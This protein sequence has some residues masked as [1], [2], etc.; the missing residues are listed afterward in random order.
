[1]I[2][3]CTLARMRKAWLGYGSGELSSR[4]VQTA[5]DLAKEGL[6]PNND[7][8]KILSTWRGKLIENTATTGIHY[9]AELSS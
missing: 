6:S 7:L 5:I 3:G 2:S 4:E 8:A 9:K 1:L